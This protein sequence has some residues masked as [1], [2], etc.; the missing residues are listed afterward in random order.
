MPSGVYPRVRSAP[1]YAEC[2]E[3]ALS[4][5]AMTGREI[6]RATGLSSHVVS[7]TLNKRPDLFVVV[8]GVRHA[9]KWGLVAM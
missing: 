9:R 5:G 7:V 4:K 2:I 3:L 1:T 8:R 6:A